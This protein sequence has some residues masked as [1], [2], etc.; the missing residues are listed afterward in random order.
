MQIQESCE[1]GFDV[2]LSPGTLLGSRA[3]L[4]R[5]LSTPQGPLPP[6]K[7]QWLPKAIYI[8]LVRIS[9]WSFCIHTGIKLGPYFFLFFF[10][11]PHPAAYG[12]SQA[13]GPV[14]ATAAGLHHSHSNVRSELRLWP[15][16]QLRKH[17]I[18]NPLSKARDWTCNL[19][20]LVGFTSAAPRWELL[21]PLLFM[22]LSNTHL[23]SWFSLLCSPATPSLNPGKCA[24]RDC[25]VIFI[26]SISF[27]IPS[28]FCSPLF[29][30]VTSA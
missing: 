25:V 14:G 23:S 22:I 11:G 10:L 15:A 20:F 4:G 3:P 1:G 8:C 12:G 30:L 18:F 19:M 17:R 27:N 9:R 29:I 21:A 28:A 26:L 6:S 7:C 16:P 24:L 2:H 5:A 13:R